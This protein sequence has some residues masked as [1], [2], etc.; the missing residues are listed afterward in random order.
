[1]ACCA[2]LDLATRPVSPRRPGKTVGSLRAG[3][4]AGSQTQLAWRRCA[5][6]SLDG[7]LANVGEN[8]TTSLLLCCLRWRP[9][10]LPSFLEL[11]DEGRLDRR[12][13]CEREGTRGVSEKNAARAGVWYSRRKACAQRARQLVLMLQPL[14]RGPV[15]CVRATSWRRRGE[16]MVRME[17]K[18]RRRASDVE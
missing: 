11:L 15:Q 8:F 6:Y 17:R 10:S 12:G 9:S 16:G 2:A 5:R 13:L 7:P 4:S 14:L 3:D 1:M 18:R